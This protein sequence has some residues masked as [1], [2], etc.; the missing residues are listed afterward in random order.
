MPE[1]LLSLFSSAKNSADSTSHL[2]QG[3]VAL[4]M[5]YATLRPTMYI[6]YY[7]Y[8]KSIQPNGESSFIYSFRQVI[9][10]FVLSLILPFKLRK[11]RKIMALSVSPVKRA[12]QRN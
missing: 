5:S 2:T 12:K 6:L 8:I 9:R 1:L 10:I 11:P 4:V 7:Q 3:S